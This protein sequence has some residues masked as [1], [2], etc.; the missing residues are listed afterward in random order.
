[1]IKQNCSQAE[2]FEKN[3]LKEPVFEQNKLKR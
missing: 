1:M 2:F 3:K